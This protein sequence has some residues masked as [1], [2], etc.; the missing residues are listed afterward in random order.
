VGQRIDN[1]LIDL[2][3]MARAQGCSAERVERRSDLPA[4]IARGIE[5][6]DAGRCHVI[7][8]VILPDYTGLL[9]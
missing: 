2:C 8:V 1:P 9:G 4:A 3:A 5:A 7:D 6:F